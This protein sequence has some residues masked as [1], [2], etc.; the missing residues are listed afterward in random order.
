MEHMKNAIVKRIS[1]VM[2]ITDADK[3]SQDFVI[4]LIKQNI[5]AF[6]KMVKNCGKS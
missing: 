1:I 3:D 2:D 5:L 4:L 6:D